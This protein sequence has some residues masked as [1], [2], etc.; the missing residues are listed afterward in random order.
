MRTL[1]AQLGLPS[2]VQAYDLMSS[3]AQYGYL[4][5]DVTPTT[6]DFLR[7]QTNLAANMKKLGSDDTDTADNP[8]TREAHFVFA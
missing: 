8:G 7:F 4:F 3:K 6:P 1:G 2:V 5:V